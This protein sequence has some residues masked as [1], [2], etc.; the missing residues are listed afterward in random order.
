MKRKPDIKNNIEVT[1]TIK[2]LAFIL[3]FFILMYLIT[4]LI[5]GEIKLN[6]KDKTGNDN[7][8]IQY[9]E[10]LAGEIFNKLEPQYY[11][12]IY[13]FNNHD[14]SIIKSLIDQYFANETAT[15]TKLYEVNLGN[16]FNKTIKSD[17]SKI[18]TSNIKELQVKDVTLI[19]V[20]DGQNILAVEG[21]TAI[22]KTLLGV[23]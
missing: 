23:N 8:A 11:V 9:Q 17:V 13:D 14:S 7:T 4:A 2:T 22:S 19:K 20:K 16:H 18:N 10:I 12:I 21:V 6:K 5:T 3:I 15:L 1:S